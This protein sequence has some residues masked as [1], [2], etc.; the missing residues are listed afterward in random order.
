[1]GES[2]A[3]RLKTKSRRVKTLSYLAPTPDVQSI[4]QLPLIHKHS[5]HQKQLPRAHSFKS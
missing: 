5:N 4:N 3:L 2:I 1:M